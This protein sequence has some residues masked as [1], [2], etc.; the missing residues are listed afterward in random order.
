MPGVRLQLIKKRRSEGERKGTKSQPQQVT[1]LPS[2]QLEMGR[3]NVP[4]GPPTS[5]LVLNMG[6]K[7]VALVTIDPVGFAG[8]TKEGFHMETSPGTA[9]SPAVP[10]PSGKLLLLLGEQQQGKAQHMSASCMPLG[11][12]AKSSWSTALQTSHPMPPVQHK[13]GHQQTHPLLQAPLDDRLALL[14]S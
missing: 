10:R 11:D 13:G 8:R 2:P 7:T 12:L 5:V 14:M 9:G 6:T 4:V 3:R 1:T